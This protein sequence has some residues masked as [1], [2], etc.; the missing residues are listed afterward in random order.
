MR[1]SPHEEVQN[2]PA[3]LASIAV[4][5]QRILLDRD[6]KTRPEPVYN[7]SGKQVYGE[8]W[9]GRYWE[10]TY[11]QVASIHGSRIEPIFF[12]VFSDSTRVTKFK[13]VEVHPIEITLTGDSLQHRQS[14]TGNPVVGYFGHLQ[15]A[16]H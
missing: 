4:E 7:E 5:M 9:T 3:Y 12:T 11:K 13:N 1:D 15:S 2:T 6:V 16:F 10:R 14:T 8:P